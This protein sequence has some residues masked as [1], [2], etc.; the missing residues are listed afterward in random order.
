MRPMLARSPVVRSWLSPRV[1]KQQGRGLAGDGLFAVVDI[2]AGE[3][4]AAKAG[5]IIDRRTLDA[6][7]D[8]VRGAELQIADDL[9]IAPLTPD[10]FDASMMCI[11]HS[12]D[13]NLGTAGNMLY[14]TMRPVSAHQELTLDYAMYATNTTQ[15]FDCLCATVHCRGRVTNQD[16]RRPDLQR[17]YRGYFSWYLQQKI[18]EST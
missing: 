10:E 15:E 12:C 1:R 4:V 5:H 14:V 16:W 6:H 11:N 7:R 13:P 3:V 18:A 2:P 17:R 9:F 8:V